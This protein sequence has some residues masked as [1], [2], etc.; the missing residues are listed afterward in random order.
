MTG[1]RCDMKDTV[2][3]N[4]T[5]NVVNDVKCPSCHKSMDIMYAWKKDPVSRGFID[6]RQFWGCHECETEVRV[7]ILLRTF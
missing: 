6:E 7:E 2:I 3:K 5:K 4:L 1:T